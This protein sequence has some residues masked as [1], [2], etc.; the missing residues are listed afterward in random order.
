MC[1]LGR[2][3]IVALHRCSF[4]SFWTGE[5]CGGLYERPH[6]EVISSARAGRGTTSATPASA[7]RY[8]RWWRPGLLT[9][10]TTVQPP[11]SLLKM[12][13]PLQERGCSLKGSWGVSPD[14]FAPRRGP[15]GPFPGKGSA[16]GSAF[17]LVLGPRVIS[18]PRSHSCAWSYHPRPRLMMISLASAHNRHAAD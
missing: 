7:R 4:T 1:S 11:Y 3:R 12:R 5:L 13:H 14:P 8:C 16:V 6:N 15:L 18:T 17:A 2:A 10:S 9:F